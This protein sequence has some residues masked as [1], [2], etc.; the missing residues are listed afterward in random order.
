MAGKKFN[1]SVT[2]YDSQ[3]DDAKSSSSLT[4]LDTPAVDGATIAQVNDNT[5]GSGNMNGG[6]SVVQVAMFSFGAGAL[7]AAGAM[8]MMKRS[9][10]ESLP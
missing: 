7:L 3:A 8:K 6:W 9:Q 10:Y 5:Y 1:D 4:L 2:I